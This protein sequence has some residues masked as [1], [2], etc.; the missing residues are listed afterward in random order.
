MEGRV[1]VVEDDALMLEFLADGLRLEGFEITK[2]DGLSKSFLELQ[3][4]APD[5]I[6]ADYQLGDGTAV[7]LL[8]WLKAHGIGIPFIVLTAHTDIQLA[9]EIVKNGTE[10]FVSKPIDFAHLTTVLRRTLENFRDRQKA[11][12]NRLDRARYER[13]PFLGSSP[14][15]LELREAATRVSKADASVL[16]G[17][18]TGSG[19]GVL[20]R[21]LHK[22]GPRSN[23]AFVDLNCAGLSSELLESELFGYRKGAFTGAVSDKIGFLEVANHG[24]LFLDEIGDLAPQVQPKILKVVEEKQFYRLGDVHERKVDVQIIAATHCDLKKLAEE[25]KF[26]SDLYFRISTLRL[27]IPPLRER[28]EDIPVITNKLL[29]QFSWDMKRGS[30]RISDNARLALQQ[31]SWP[32]NIRELRNVLERAALLSD[33]GLIH[34]TGLEFEISERQNIAAYVPVAN[35]TL[36]EMEKLYILQTLLSEGG[37]VTQTAKRLGMPRSSLYAKIQ[38]HGLQSPS[39]VLLSVRNSE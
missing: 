31:Y 13:D 9:V 18:E 23:A 2:A 7:D 5:V 34:K 27:H 22:M 29:E 26:R 32:G 38:Q 6:L 37:R 20:A 28:R 4:L 11:L 8:A 21:W 12:A 36:K 25:G 17:G 33:G 30:L 24:T 3:K 35:L 10:Q 16:I 15:I 39:S 14:A 1:L 19:K